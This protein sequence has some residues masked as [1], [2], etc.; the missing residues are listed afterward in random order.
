[1]IIAM[2]S[3]CT[4]HASTRFPLLA[5]PIT[6]LCASYACVQAVLRRGCIDAMAN[7]WREQLVIPGATLSGCDSLVVTTLLLTCRRSCV[8]LLAGGK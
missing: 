7:G 2:R 4:A 3:T 6:A 5:H 1:V 8:S